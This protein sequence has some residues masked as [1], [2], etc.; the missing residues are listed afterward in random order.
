MFIE[1]CGVR[2]GVPL[3]LKISRTNI[4]Q[5]TVVFRLWKDLSTVEH[6]NDNHAAIIYK[7]HAQ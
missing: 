1:H 6:R 2:L 5:A 7:E 4:N 3:Y